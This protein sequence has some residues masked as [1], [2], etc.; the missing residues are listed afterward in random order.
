MA[1][2]KEFGQFLVGFM[3]RHEKW[4]ST[5]GERAQMRDLEAKEDLLPVV[6]LGWGDQAEEVVDEGFDVC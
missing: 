1:P 6:G 2:E 4:F 3:G 5:A